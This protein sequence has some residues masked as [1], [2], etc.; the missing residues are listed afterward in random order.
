MSILDYEKY[1]CITK[2]S[3]TGTVTSFFNFTVQNS[4][5][6]CLRGALHSH[7]TDKKMAQLYD[8]K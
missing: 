3:P 7:A 5:R 2:N 8:L 6:W 1:F 4:R